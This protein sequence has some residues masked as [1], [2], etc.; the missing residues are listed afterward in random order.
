MMSS[1]IH[2]HAASRGRHGSDDP[3]R[4]I[5]GVLG[6]S[7][8]KFTPANVWQPS[9]NI[10]EDDTAYF[11]VADLAGVSVESIDLRLE[12]R[13]LLLS[14][15]RQM[16]APPQCRSRPRLHVMEI[17]HGDFQRLIKLP[18][19]VDPDGIT[20]NYKCGLL[21]IQIPKAR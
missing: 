11:V 6:R 19:N 15:T 20:A 21:T 13:H 18:P 2:I 1:A 4:W 17:D 10:C 7:Y 8:Q 5:E 12:N 14:G 16:P 3:S 9:V